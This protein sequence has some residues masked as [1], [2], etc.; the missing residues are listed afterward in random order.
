MEKISFS[1]M[2]GAGNDFIVLDLDAN[3]KFSLNDSTIKNLCN[4]RNGIGADGVIT[5][6]NNDQYDFEMKY[7][8]ADGST[9]SLCGNGARCA[10]KFA[11]LSNRLK[12]GTAKFLSNGELYSGEILD[13]N[14]IKFYFNSPRKIKRNFMLKAADQLIKTNYINTG[15]PHVVIKIED[16]LKNPK[17]LNS[18]YNN[19]DEFPVFQ[20]G[21]EIRYHKDFSPEGAN[22]NFIKI[23]NRKIYIRTYERGVEDETL[24]CGSGSAAA[25]L[26]GFFNEE[27]NPPI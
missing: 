18:S 27:L 24:A 16:V 21:K 23:T 14:R 20:L 10:I 15:S 1:K 19:L 11:Q 6:S 13:K 5:I 2:S 3:P 26:I 12:N 22:I 17:N 25:A 8:N 7:F 4:R 9:G